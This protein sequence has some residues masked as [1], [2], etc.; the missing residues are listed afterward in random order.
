MKI[1]KW[2]NQHGMILVVLIIIFSIGYYIVGTL[3]YTIETTPDIQEIGGP[4]SLEHFLMI[5]AVMMIMVLAL[6]YLKRC[7]GVIK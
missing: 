4:P 6:E 5:I 2:L 3:K 1:R 7:E